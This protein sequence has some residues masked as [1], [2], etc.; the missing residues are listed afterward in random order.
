MIGTLAKRENVEQKKGHKLFI[1]LMCLFVAMFFVRNAFKINFPVVV[2]LGLAAVIAVIS[3]REELISLIVSFIPLS[4]GFQYK[5]AILL[6]IAVYFMKFAKSIKRPK[7]A[8]AIVA[9]FVWELLHT[10][11]GVFSPVEA[12]RGFSELIFFAIILMADDFDFS[13]GLPMRTLAYCSVAAIII[14]MIISFSRLGY[15]FKEFLESGIRF[16]TADKGIVQFGFNFNQ[17][18][19]GFM[20][21]LSLSGLLILV[22]DKKAKLLD[23]LVIGFLVFTGFL[24]MS[25]AFIICFIGIVLAYAF[26]QR[27]SLKKKVAGFIATI[28]FFVVI[29]LLVNA[30]APTVVENVGERF[31]EEDITSGRDQLFEFY[32]KHIFSNGRYL[33]FGVGLQNYG[34]KVNEIYRTNMSV[35]HNGYQEI[36]VAWGIIGFLLVAYL[37]Y[38]VFDRT[39]H[40]HKWKISLKWLPLGT[41]LVYILSSQFISQGFHLMCF[42]FA[43]VCMWYTT[44]KGVSEGEKNEKSNSDNHNT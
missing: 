20:C 4:V 26:M 38:M 41:L 1:A 19:M 21:N 14:V 15:N 39:R 12:L 3:D 10:F 35:C 36:V 16:G 30:I 43:A 13:D 9:L 42:I 34:D 7:Y 31:E 11:T 22:R 18:N 33:L 44:E 23:Y 40:I 27:G 2:F 28:A 8:F 24:T 29:I 25:R 6:C 5:Y 32:N 37:V 17:N